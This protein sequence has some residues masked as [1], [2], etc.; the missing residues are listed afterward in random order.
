[1]LGALAPLGRPLATDV[2]AG[3]RAEE[4]LDLPI[5][6]RLRTGWPTTGLWL[7][8]AGKMSAVDPRASLA[9]PHDD[10]LAPLPLTGATAEAMETWSTTG[11][12][13]GEAGA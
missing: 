10:D 5:I 1:M 4:G 13:Q 7:V 6:E 2:V 12:R 3:A 8:G 11:G 9:R